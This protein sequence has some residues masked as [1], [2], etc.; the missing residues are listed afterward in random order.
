MQRAGLIALVIAALSASSAL[1]LDDQHAERGTELAAKAVEYLRTQQDAETGGWSVNP[2][3]PNLPGLSALVLTGLLMEPGVDADD[4]TI[5]AGLSFL[6]RHRKQD[7]SIHDDV[8]PSYNTALALSAF[9]LAT[10]PD[11][12]V[13]DAQTFLRSNQWAGQDDPNGTAVD[14]SHPYFGGVGYGRH[15]RPDL[16]NLAMT[17]QALHDSGVDPDD[18]AFQRALAFLQRTQM[19]DSVNDMSYADGSQQGGFIYSTSTSKDAIGAGESKAGTIEE[20]VGEGRAVSRLRAY[21]SMTYAGF[22][23]YLYADLTRDD[24]RVV[25]AHDWIRRNYTVM[26]NPSIGLQGFYY[27]IV[28]MS[29][30][31]RA[32]GDET[33]TPLDGEDSAGEPQDW[34]NDI[35]DRLA[36]LQQEDGSFRVLHERWMEDDPALIASYALLALHNALD[37]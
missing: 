16:S 4:P 37:R 28:T 32:Y 1:G 20:T 19:L 25:A 3:G 35:I 31:L 15:G 5:Q 27:Y 7:G 33:V 14:A 6:L 11:T 17:L 36:A 22:K 21:G 18:P 10:V 9:S 2:T 29:R 26:E 24:P 13:A 8:L 30:A 23:S 34:A 12:V